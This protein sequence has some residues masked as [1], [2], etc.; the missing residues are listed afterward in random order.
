MK[1]SL[2]ISRIKP[3]SAG[4]VLGWVTARDWLLVT[5]IEGLLSNFLSYF[6]KGQKS[7]SVAGKYVYMSYLP[8]WFSRTYRCSKQRRKT[9][10]AIIS[11][12]KKKEKKK[13]KK[14]WI[15]ENS[16]L[17]VSLIRPLIHPRQRN[18][19]YRSWLRHL[20]FGC[21]KLISASDQMHWSKTRYG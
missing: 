20:V 14:P 11:I 3:C 16:C 7:K 12:K 4:L 10:F 18:V 6:F 19:F 13:F 9:L 2:P 15:A 5:F 21:F 8:I 1:T 17:G